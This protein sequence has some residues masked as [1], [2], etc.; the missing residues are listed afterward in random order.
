MFTTDLEQRPAQLAFEIMNAARSVKA[1][2]IST[3]IRILMRL[4]AVV[5]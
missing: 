2:G 4:L 5:E 3:R 1:T